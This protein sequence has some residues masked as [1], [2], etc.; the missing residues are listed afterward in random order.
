MPTAD[1][2]RARIC[3]EL[4]Y[5]GDDWLD[6]ACDHIRK[7]LA[8]IAFTKTYDTSTVG[9]RLKCAR[10]CAGL[11]QRELARRVKMTQL[12]ISECER[13]K[14]E[15]PAIKV[16]GICLSLAIKVP[17][18]LIGEGDG[19]PKVAYRILRKDQSV[20]DLKKL[21]GYE[22]QQAAVAE[23]RRRNEER[24]CRRRQFGSPPMEAGHRVNLDTAASDAGPSTYHVPCQHCLTLHHDSQQS[25]RE[26]ELHSKH[27]ASKEAVEPFR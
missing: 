17:W 1:D 19:G 12:H 20:K 21:K 6:V 22:R 16:P 26:Q 27:Q 25:C 24:K 15:L 14:R 3:A 18:L 11:L 4:E 23:A 2:I 10:E 7:R 13:G 8:T 9:G 5:D